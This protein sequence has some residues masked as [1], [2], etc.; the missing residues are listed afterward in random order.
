LSPGNSSSVIRC[1]GLVFEKIGRPLLEPVAAENSVS[2]ADLELSPGAEKAETASQIRVH[3][4]L[5][6]ILPIDRNPT[7]GG[8]HRKFAGLPVEL[9]IESLAVAQR[10]HIVTTLPHAARIATRRD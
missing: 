9:K 4:L 7:D 5:V 3:V 1:G 8:M 2:Q 10:P 6:N